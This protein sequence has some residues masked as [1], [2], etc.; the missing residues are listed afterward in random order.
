MWRLLEIKRSLAQSSCPG[1]FRGWMCARRAQFK[2]LG[3][4]VGSADWCGDVL[5]RRVQKAWSL[6]SSMDK[7]DDTQG[8]FALLR[9]C[10]GLAK[11]LYSCSTVLH[12]SGRSLSFLLTVNF[13]WLWLG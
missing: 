1:E 13:G 12:P 7:Y 5:L 3:S 6:I 10:S 11:I 9:S 2:L 8:A 4:G